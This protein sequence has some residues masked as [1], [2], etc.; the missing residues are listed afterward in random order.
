M[1]VGILT[2]ELHVPESGSLKGK[3]SVVKGLKDRIRSRF[4][5]SVAEVGET[6][7]WQRA[8]L[9]IAVVS[10]DRSHADEVLAKVVDLIRSNTSAELL[11]YQ[12]E[13]V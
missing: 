2:A 5:V 3:R 4:N 1:F 11:D 7:L 12:I 9:G 6:E 10:N 8:T 13:I